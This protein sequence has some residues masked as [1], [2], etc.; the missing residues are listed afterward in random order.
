MDG[1]N[2]LWPIVIAMKLGVNKLVATVRLRACK[3][4]RIAKLIAMVVVSV[5]I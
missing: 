1:H 3:Y 4:I 2:C 5:F